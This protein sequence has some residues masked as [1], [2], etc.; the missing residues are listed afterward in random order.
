MHSTEGDEVQLPG[1]AIA[2]ARE[3]AALEKAGARWAWEAYN[4]TATRAEKAA[5]GFSEVGGRGPRLV[6][7]ILQFGV[8]G[9]TAVW[10]GSVRWNCRWCCCRRTG[11][12]ARVSARGG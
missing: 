5:W 9:F 12:A 7:E 10:F 3:N 2:A 6:A 8:A 11:L 4:R 1:H